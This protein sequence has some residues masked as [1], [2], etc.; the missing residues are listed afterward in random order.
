MTTFVK[1]VCFI[2]T[3]FKERRVAK[4]KM[5][6][7][8]IALQ[9]EA[10]CSAENEGNKEASL[11]EEQLSDSQN[12]IV[13]ISEGKQLSGVQNGIVQISECEE[14]ERKTAKRGRKGKKADAEKKLTPL[15]VAAE[16]IADMLSSLS[17]DRELFV[18]SHDEKPQ[19]RLDTKTLKEF[20]SVIK[21]ITGVICELNGISSGKNSEGAGAVK[22]EFDEDAEACSQ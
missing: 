13:Q 10:V 2:C 20:S 14:K 1:A 21:E 5:R 6:D 4:K 17:E 9:A 8:G 18:V 3:E 15:K 11:T 12:G 19:R 22:I 7:I 16:N